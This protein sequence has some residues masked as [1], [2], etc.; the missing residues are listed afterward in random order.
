MGR[1]A[2]KKKTS[3]PSHRVETTHSV[4]LASHSKFQTTIIFVHTVPRSS[5]LPQAL[6]DKHKDVKPVGLV[7]SA[8]VHAPTWVHDIFLLCVIVRFFYLFTIGDL[9]SDHIISHVSQSANTANM[10]SA[11]M[12][13]LIWVKPA[14]AGFMTRSGGAEL[15]GVMQSLILGADPVNHAVNQV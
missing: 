3:I 9:E 15:L 7:V 1:F 2:V 6:Q 8:L 4:T 5:F 10:R 11:G 14:A 12:K 13:S